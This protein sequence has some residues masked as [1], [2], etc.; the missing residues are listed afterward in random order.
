MKSP[1][2][3]AISEC[4]RTGIRQQLTPQEIE[5]FAHQNQRELA[6]K[7]EAIRREQ[8]IRYDASK[9]LIVD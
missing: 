8:R 6:P 9:R 2:S 1:L 3:R 7:I 4:L 5:S